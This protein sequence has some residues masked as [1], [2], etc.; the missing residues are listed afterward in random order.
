[1]GLI[2]QVA[3]HE[4]SE[5]GTTEAHVSAEREQ[6]WERAGGATFS[7][8]PAGPG[9]QLCLCGEAPGLKE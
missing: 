9:T 5:M 8:P 1:M 4:L 3:P 6:G 2:V 7:P